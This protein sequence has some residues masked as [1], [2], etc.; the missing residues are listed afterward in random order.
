[1]TRSVEALTFDLTGDICLAKEG[2]SLVASDLP[3][4]HA[5]ALG[6]LLELRH[7][8]PELV[9][10]Q[11]WLTTTF[12]ATL[13]MNLSSSK[14]W[15]Y[16]PEMGRQGF[17][18]TA[19]LQTD[20]LAWP[21]F[22]IRSKRAAKDAGFSDDHSAKLTAAIGEFYSNVV[23][24]SNNVGSGYVVFCAKNRT[25]EFV[26]ADEGIGVLNSLRGNPNFVNLTD[27]G[28]A[29]ELALSEGISRHL[30]PGR[31]SGFRPLFI[32]LANISRFIRFRSSDH[33]REL[34]RAADGNIKALTRQASNLRG[35]FCSVL[36]ESESS[37]RP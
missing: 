10:D 33:S 31:G 29:L 13:L 34:V 4:I 20:P 17:V 23:E 9:N 21:D 15:W 35:F 37:G 36:C 25:F 14:S 24:H 3:P 18:S 28:T 19:R 22:L 7:I 26:V 27:S 30:E 32:G 6:P 16:E 1:M 11:S 8:R 5:D 2:G 12:Y